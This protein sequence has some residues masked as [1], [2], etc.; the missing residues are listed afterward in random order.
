MTNYAKIIAIFIRILNIDIWYNL[1]MKSILYQQCEALN[2]SSLP[3]ISNISN[4]LALLYHEMGDVN[5]IGFYLC[6][7]QK[8]ECLLG[9][10][11]GKVAC[12]RIQY[13]LGVVGTCAQ[14]QKT[15]VVDDVHQFPGHIA[16]DAAS[17]SEIVIPLKKDDQ[18]VAILDIDSPIT[19]R[20]DNSIK[21]TLEDISLILS[22]LISVDNI[23]K[24]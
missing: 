23:L 9:P 21:E 7:D 10:F 4:I 19:H 17:Q 13:G 15:I 24:D 8:Q 18:L 2:D 20:F 14:R 12:T 6:N 22:D 5:W 16:C 11:Q 1:T 3:A